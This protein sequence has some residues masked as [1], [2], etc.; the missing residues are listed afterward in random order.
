MPEPLDE[1]VYRELV[2][3][4][5]AEDVGTGD[6]TTAAVVAPDLDAQAVLLAKSSCVIAGLDVAREVFRQADAHVVFEA[7]RRDGEFC[8][9]GD[10][11]AILRGG[12]AGLLVAERTALNFLQ[13]L[14][15]IATT[16][17]RFVDAAAGRIVVLDTRKT[18]P[19]FRRLAKY[20]VRCGGA[21]NYRI[22]L[23]DGILIKDNHIRAAGGIAEA[24]RR[25]RATNTLLP[26]EV[27][28][29]TLDEVDDA[30]AAGADTIMLDNFTDE[31]TWTAVARIGGRARIELSGNMSIE[32]VRALAACGADFVSIGAM[33]HSAPAAD[34]SLEIEIDTGG[35]PDQQAGTS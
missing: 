13:Y 8:R 18:T 15:G 30:I 35:T 31:Q 9:A 20:A 21:A 27:E 3:E 5:L 34:I 10:R 29:Q 17:R 33:T 24:V 26:I 2:R 7:E 32:R 28:A 22:G 23:Y 11:I 4:A 1:H 14:S 25:V 6:I 12:A 16:A 19:M